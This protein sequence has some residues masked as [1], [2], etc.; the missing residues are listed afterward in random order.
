M[1]TIY[2]IALFLLASWGVLIA[3]P[4]TEKGWLAYIGSS[5]LTG[6]FLALVYLVKLVLTI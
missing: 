4:L 5:V 6:A 3:V 1:S 2:L